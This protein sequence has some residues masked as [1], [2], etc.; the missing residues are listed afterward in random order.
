[1]MSL[2]IKFNLIGEAFAKTRNRDIIVDARPGGARHG[3]GHID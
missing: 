3:I 2:N 1:M